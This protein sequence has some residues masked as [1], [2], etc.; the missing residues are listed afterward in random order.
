MI[1]S[2]VKKFRLSTKPQSTPPSI[3]PLK[4]ILILS[5]HHEQVS[6][7]VPVTQTGNTFVRCIPFRKVHLLTARKH[8]AITAYG[9]RVSTVSISYLVDRTSSHHGTCYTTNNEILVSSKPFLC[10]TQKGNSGF[11][12]SPPPTPITST[13]QAPDWVLSLKSEALYMK[14]S[15]LYVTVP[16]CRK[17]PLCK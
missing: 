16:L 12:S 7:Y 8:P 9:L 5:S 6:S 14:V 4:L 2:R 17:W 3:S 10:P 15:E 13:C 1:H 11:P